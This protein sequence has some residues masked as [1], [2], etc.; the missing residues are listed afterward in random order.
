MCC[1]LLPFLIFCFC[2]INAD[3]YFVSKQE[4]CFFQ[5]AVL[6][7]AVL[8]QQQQNRTADTMG[9][10]DLRTWVSDKLM[11]LLGYSQATVVQY[12][13]GLCGLLLYSLFCMLYMFEHLKIH[14]PFSE[15]LLI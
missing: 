13:I 6:L 3:L 10:S 15:A 1:K 9:D 11:S 5:S 2:I 8:K 7:S 14:V 12:I 4:N